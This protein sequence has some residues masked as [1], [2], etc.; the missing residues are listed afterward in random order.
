MLRDFFSYYLPHRRLFLIDF[1]SAV[2]R[3]P[4]GGDT[5]TERRIQA[6]LEELSEGR[7]VLVIAHRLATIRGVDRITVVEDGRIGESGSHRSLLA[8]GGLYTRLDAAQSGG[9]LAAE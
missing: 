1:G 7:T 6:A 8:A 5:E 9:V 2:P 3:L 4:A